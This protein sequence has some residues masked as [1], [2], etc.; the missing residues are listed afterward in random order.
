MDEKR[1]DRIAPGKVQGGPFHDLLF[2]DPLLKLEIKIIPERG[3][4]PSPAKPSLSPAEP[5]ES[6]ARLRN[7]SSTAM[8]A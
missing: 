3:L 4:C 8:L 5:K 2:I 7:T 1:G 6:V